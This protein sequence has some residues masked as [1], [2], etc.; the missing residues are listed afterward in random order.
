MHILYTSLLQLQYKKPIACEKKK[1]RKIPCLP[2][3]NNL[4]A[5]DSKNHQHDWFRAR[6]NDAIATC[7]GEI[8]PEAVYGGGDDRFAE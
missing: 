6:S 7:A 2:K 3:A 5:G 4:R 1:E 8:N